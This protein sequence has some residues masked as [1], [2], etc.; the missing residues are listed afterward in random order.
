MTNRHPSAMEGAL[1]SEYVA[2]VLLRF[3]TQRNP[4]L[5]INLLALNLSVFT[6]LSEMGYKQ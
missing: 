4:M 3:D 2:N 6:T 1:V 5:V